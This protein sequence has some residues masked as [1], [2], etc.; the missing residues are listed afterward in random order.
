MKDLLAAHPVAGE[1]PATR[2]LA[3]ARPLTIATALLALALGGAAF[4]AAPHGFGGGARAGFG[5]GAHVGF[6]GGA[7]AGFAARG[8]AGRGF[9]GRGFPGHGGR[10]RP[11]YG[12]RGRGPG[13]GW[14]W[15][16]GFGLGWYVPVLPLYYS[17]FWWD[18]VPYYYADND[19]YEW[20]PTVGQYEAVV[21]PPGVTQQPQGGVASAAGAPESSE[22]FAYPKNGQS[23]AQQASDKEQCRAWARSQV[24]ATL[25]PNDG[26]AARSGDGPGRTAGNTAGGA[27]GA[28]PGSDA[29]AVGA[30][31]QA[32]ASSAPPPSS[33]TGLPGTAGA[34]APS[35]ADTVPANDAQRAAYLRAE[36][37]CLTGRGYSVQ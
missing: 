14:G 9:A 3:R 19:Y 32:A 13:W 17:T 34:T 25:T 27:P 12:W 21:P 36:A 31:Q 5:G 6:G 2:R 1:H 10:F 33:A 4:A 11:N 20:N 16:W 22:L 23:P 8:F 7:H 18:G 30:L 28:T 24:G 35:P 37:A 29:T 15:G 26:A